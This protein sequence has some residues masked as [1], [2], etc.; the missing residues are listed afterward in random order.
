MQI[1]YSLVTG[2]SI[3]YKYSRVAGTVEAFSQIKNLDYFHSILTLL[4]ELVTTPQQLYSQLDRAKKTA[5]KEDIYRSKR[6]K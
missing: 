6:T 1:T 3:L 2:I 4:T 5:C